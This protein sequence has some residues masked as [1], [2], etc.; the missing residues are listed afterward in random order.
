MSFFNQKE[1]VLNLQL[2]KHGRKNLGLGFFNPVFCSFFDDSII[3][4]NSYAGNLHE[5]T[6]FIQD[7]ILYHS[8]TLKSLNNLEDTLTSPLGNSDIMSDYAPA[9]DL[10][11]LRGNIE[12]LSASS[13]YYK[14][15]F[16]F[17]DITYN[18]SIE[19]EN[20]PLVQNLEALNFSLN[21]EK[22][23]LV[24]EDYILIELEEKNVKGGTKNFELELV[25]FDQLL[26]GKEAGLERRLK[27]LQKQNNIV[28]DIIYDE[29]E[30]PTNFINSDI[31]SEDVAFYFD[32]LVDNE[33]DINIIK[34]IEKTIESQ[35]KGT[36]TSNFGDSV[37]EEDC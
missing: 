1:E 34:P 12:F 32:L 16:E 36:Y 21:E 23:L 18:I 17:A 5:D 24:E 27:F 35:V 15:F 22:V 11:L 30:L 14:K 19:K 31:S 37:K 29:S 13:S 10:K 25:T 20:S 8:L 4:D 33:I 28:D 7:R 6:N 9:W 26:G 2:T 3:Y